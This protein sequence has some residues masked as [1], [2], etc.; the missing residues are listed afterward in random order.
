MYILNIPLPFTSQSALPAHSYPLFYALLNRSGDWH[1]LT[2]VK[3]RIIT[4][5]FIYDFTLMV[6][7]KNHKLSLT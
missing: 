2:Y 4:S 7:A 5:A 6:A 3:N 1:P